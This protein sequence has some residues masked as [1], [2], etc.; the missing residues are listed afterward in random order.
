MIDDQNA[1]ALAHT[2]GPIGGTGVDEDGAFDLPTRQ[3][4]HVIKGN[5]LLYRA[6]NPRTLRFSNVGRTG[7]ASGKKID[8]PSSDASASKSVCSWVRMISND[9]SVMIL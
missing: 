9:S 4:V 5:R 3:F 6:K 7:V 8:A 2:L 1:G